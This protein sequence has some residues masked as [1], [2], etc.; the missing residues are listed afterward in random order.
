M[1]GG[2]RSSDEGGSA[3]FGPKLCLGRVH[4]M[5]EGSTH[6]VDEGGIGHTV[7]VD[8]TLGCAHARRR[9]SQADAHGDP[10]KD[11]VVG[12]TPSRDSAAELYPSMIYGKFDGMEITGARHSCASMV[13]RHADMPATICANSSTTLIKGSFVEVDGVVVAIF[14]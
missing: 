5:H 13:T 4:A 14:C 11:A 10:T 3:F 2:S 7:D 8:V 1:C 9:A 6:A 12:M